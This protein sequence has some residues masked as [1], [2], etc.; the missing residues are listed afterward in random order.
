MQIGVVEAYA[1]TGR[2]GN[3]NEISPLIE[4]GG[5]VMDPA[6][7]PEPTPDADPEN[8]GFEPVPTVGTWDDDEREPMAW[9][10]RMNLVLV[11]LMLA[12]VFGVGAVLH[13]YEADG[14]PKSQET[15]R[16]L[17]LPPCSFYAVTGLPCPSCGFTTSFSLVAHADVWNA[18]KANSVGTLLAMFCYLVVPWAF[19]SA[20]RKR[21]LFVYSA[22]KLL[23]TSLIVFVVLML[24]RWGI[25]L[26]L[27]RYEG[28]F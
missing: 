11:G 15:H 18:L 8:P 28:R 23:I 25:I 3:Y 5:L 24:T 13:P 1:D 20:W 6:S 26:G 12:A 4:F 19:I 14:K 7:V 27:A 16:Q 10:V 22:E 17:G 9:W 21:Y 2:S